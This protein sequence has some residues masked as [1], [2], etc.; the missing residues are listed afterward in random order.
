MTDYDIEVSSAKAFLSDNPDRLRLALAVEEAVE[1]LRE[2]MADEVYPKIRAAIG[3]YSGWE[4]TDECKQYKPLFW[5]RLYKKDWDKKGWKKSE[6]TGVWVGRWKSERLALDV[7]A[8]GWPATRRSLDRAIRETFGKFITGESVKLWRRNTRN[9][10]PSRRVSWQ[11]DGDKAFM[12]GNVDEEV[13]RLADLM[14]ALV[15]AIDKPDTQ[16]AM[17]PRAERP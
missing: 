3:G 5:R 7:C 13:A 11:L 4:V 2:E 15:E 1:A 16:S 12:I 17:V 10:D 14:S 8:E 9:S 6:F